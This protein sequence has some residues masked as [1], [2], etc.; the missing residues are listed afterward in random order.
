MLQPT[1]QHKRTKDLYLTGK[2]HWLLGLLLEIIA[3][4]A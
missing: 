2:Q 1:E 4:A 3:A